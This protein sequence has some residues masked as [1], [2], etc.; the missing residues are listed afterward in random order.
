MLCILFQF[1]FPLLVFPS[2]FPFSFTFA[3]VMQQKK[4]SKKK[5]LLFA[6]LIISKATPFVNI[7][8]A[9]YICVELSILHLQALCNMFLSFYG[10]N[11]SL[12]MF[13]TKSHRMFRYFTHFTIC[14]FMPPESLPDQQ[15]PL[16]RNSKLPH[17]VSSIAYSPM[18][19]M[20]LYFPCPKSSV[21]T[22]GML[23]FC[24]IRR[25][26]SSRI[27]QCCSE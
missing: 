24:P 1:L 15:P 10:L 8:P 21:R 2:H 22:T 26:I 25:R 18:G 3:A 27:G 13:R 12:C 11:C 4:N 9:L 5:A 6:V 20:A 23:C 19:K 14:L 17:S 7:L 16:P